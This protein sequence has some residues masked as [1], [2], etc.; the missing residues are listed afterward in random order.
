MTLF[1]GSCQKDTQNKSSN[2]STHSQS[3]SK[4][5]L[6]KIPASQS[7]I[8]F[9]NFIKENQKVHFFI[10]NFIYQG[11]GVAI[12]DINNDGLQDIYFSGNMASDKL[13]LNK[14]NFQFEDISSSSGIEDRLWSTGVTMVDINA[15]GLLDIY[16][17]KNFF[18][19]Q[20]GVRK[21]KLFINNG[22]LTFTEKA[23]TYGIDDAGYSVQANFLD[24]DN[25]GDLDLYLVNQPMDQYAAQMAKKETLKKLPFSDKFYRNN[26]G[27]FSDETEKLKLKNRS[28]GLNA[29]AS[30]F[31]DNGWSDIYISNDYNQ[32]DQFMINNGQMNFSNEI[33]SRLD[34]TSFYSMGSDVAD[35]NNDGWLDFMTLDMAF[36][37]HYRSKTNMESM[38]PEL[39]W[40]LVNEGNHYQYAVNN[41]QLNDG[42]GYFSE[43]AHLS[44]VSHTDWSW[45]PLFIDLDNDS[46]K[47]LLISN[48]L[49]KDLR[50]NDFLNTVRKVNSGDLSSM[51]FE[52]INALAPSTPV[53][54][55][56]FQ[57]QGDLT[58]KNVSSTCG[59]SEK[60]FS[61]GMAYG[62]LDNDGDFDIVINNSNAPA[63][64]FENTN[65]S[66]NNYINIKLKGKHNNTNGIGAKVKV[67]YDGNVQAGD[68]ITVRGYMSSSQDMLS[69]GLGQNSKVDSVIVYWDHVTQ[70]LILNPKINTVLNIDYESTKAPRTAHTNNIQLAKNTKLIDYKHKENEH[71]DYASQVLL[72][73][74][75]SQNGPYISV[76]DITGD[77]RED[78]YIGGAKGQAGQ[79]FTQTLEEDFKSSPLGNAADENLQNHFVHLNG[80]ENLDLIMA[81][82]GHEKENSSFN[83]FSNIRKAL[84]PVLLPT[85]AVNDAQV[86]LAEDFNGDGKKDLFIGGRSVPGN[87]PQPADSYIF[88]NVNGQYSNKTAEIAPDLNA[89]G[90]VTDAIADDVDLDGDMDLLIVGEWMPLTLFINENGQFKKQEIDIFGHNS[91]AWWWSIEKGDFDKDGDNDFLIGNL[92]LNNKFHPSP[93][94]PFQ[95][96][97]S[98]FDNNGDNDVVLAKMID[99]KTFPVRGR[100]C[101]T[102]E[103]PFISEKFK[104]FDAF[105]KASLVDIFSEQKLNEALN[106]K[107]KT[108]ESIYLE[109]KGS[110]NFVAKSLPIQAQFG[111]IKDFCVLDF[112]KDGNKDF[113]FGGN[114]YP[115]EVETV[116]YDANKGGVCLGDGIG[117]FKFISASESGIYLNQDVRDLEI[118]N[119]NNKLYLL[120]TV[121][122]GEL[123]S[124]PITQ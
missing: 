53:S 122:D 36:G 68:M 108:F 92:G 51:P 74:K 11:A 5:R 41:L 100:E 4:I 62:D 69:F 117:H 84:R 116:R 34:H 96:F 86:I 98:D 21:N 115:V 119:M 120:A 43:I 31:T 48:G 65:I 59:F 13:Y 103:M 76:G 111:P 37:D 38:R 47:D 72:P 105:A 71:D 10:W 45:S 49:L 94:K 33:Q 60:G 101:S 22:D 97:A 35:I 118:I 14:G 95:I 58:F 64:I 1:L 29:L 7:N 110:N 3:T 20:E 124:I 107:I 99:N 25:D 109:N 75:L 123:I 91:N 15:D 6:K 80:D 44:G 113:I 54:N 32:G 61:S 26:N 88:L 87:Y 78:V 23:P 18:L 70:S 12:G 93:S 112:N 2:S 8:T 52:Q 19:L 30:D 56:A 77:N 42:H 67:H 16:V 63:S 27:K 121:N 102:E 40:K 114:H 85:S 89:L 46:Y 57:N 55:Y 104:D 106:Y 83:I 28:Y 50:N 90:L 39:F 73:H 79:F 17:C 81:N 24:A 9:N 82:G 66:K